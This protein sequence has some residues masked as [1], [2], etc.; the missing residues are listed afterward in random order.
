MVTLPETCR[1]CGRCC[2]SVGTPPFTD[3]ERQSLRKELSDDLKKYD[4]RKNGMICVWL[5]SD[6]ECSQYED[7]PKLCRDFERGSEACKAYL[8]N[9]GA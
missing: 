4:G 2:L 7:R 8:I 1:G 6:M 3:K 9:F 5:N